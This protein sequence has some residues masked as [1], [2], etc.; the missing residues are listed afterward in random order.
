M[1]REIL[2]YSGWLSYR[3]IKRMQEIA[4]SQNHPFYYDRY[5]RFYFPVGQLIRKV[6]FLEDYQQE[7]ILGEDWYIFYL[8]DFDQI[9]ILDWAAEANDQVFVRTLEMMRAFQKIFIDN[10]TNL[11]AAR[12]RQSTSYLFYKAAERFH[13]VKTLDESL[14]FDY[15]TPSSILKEIYKYN[16]VAEFLACADQKIIEE[17]SFFLFHEIE[18]K[19][20]EKCFGDPEELL[21][22][23]RVPYPVDDDE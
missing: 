2:E 11:G 6:F 10:K 21:N 17:A 23:K 7:L 4:K 12:M 3:N 20:M 5:Y 1:A 15:H 16:S 18:F 22:R 9:Q 8:K 14:K 13:F 19:M